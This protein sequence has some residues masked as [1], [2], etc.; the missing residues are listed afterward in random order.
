MEFFRNSGAMITLSQGKAHLHAQ[1]HKF[2]ILHCKNTFVDPVI[3]AFYSCGDFGTDPLQRMT[4]SNFKSLEDKVEELIRL[5]G[6]MKKENQLLRDRESQ[7]RHEKE[8]LLGNQTVAR[9]RLEK[10]L[11]RLKSLEE[12][13]A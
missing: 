9:V 8:T 4:N 6:D 3:T 7:L 13:Q 2:L 12:G 11:R 5:C 10:V 1:R